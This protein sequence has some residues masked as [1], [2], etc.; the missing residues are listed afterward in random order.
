MH[1]ALTMSGSRQSR[2][3]GAGVVLSGDA[4]AVDALR[5]AVEDRLGR[6]DVALPLLP[7]VASQVL[8]LAS[9]PTA[10]AARLSAL[11]HRDPA[12]AAHVLRVANSPAYMPRM[13]IVSLQ[14]AVARLGLD[15]VTEI[16]LVASLRGG[17]FKV[18]GYERELELLWRHAVA[19]SLFAKEIARVRRSNVEAAFLGGL[20]HAVGKPAVLQLVA[21]VEVV[22]V[23]AA[24]AAC[25]A[26]VPALLDEL[27]VGVGLRIAERWSLPRAVASAIAH[28]VLY[29]D[30]GAFKHEA[31]ITCLADRLATALCEP[32]RFDDATL[33]AHE[34]FADLNLYPDDVA[35]LLGKRARVAELVASMTA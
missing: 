34:V 29:A 16:A 26:A 14:Q 21:S 5:A 8:S 3:T 31:M 25:R 35:S 13:P 15:T 17:T 4:D 22:A 23:G 32:A 27:H 12:L 19:S 9:D 33:V 7:Q 30:A 18:A 1:D 10:D 11:I 2:P 24:Q 6:G 28:H 20:L